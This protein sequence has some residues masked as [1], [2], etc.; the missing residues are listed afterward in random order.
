M[1]LFIQTFHHYQQVIEFTELGE[2]ELSNTYLISS[3]TNELYQEITNNALNFNV[4]YKNRGL[5]NIDESRYL[6]NIFG[7]KSYFNKNGST[8]FMNRDED[9]YSNQSFALTEIN[10]QLAIKSDGLT[11]QSLYSE[12]FESIDGGLISKNPLPNTNMPPITFDYFC[13]YFYK[14]DTIIPESKMYKYA[15]FEYTS[16]SKVKISIISIKTHTLLAMVYILLL[17]I[18]NM[19]RLTLIKIINFQ[20]ILVKILIQMQN[21]N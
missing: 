21:L 5:E 1:Q 18:I 11:H 2:Y 16:D 14:N 15:S 7:V 10:T 6:L 19:L 13:S 12:L 8:E 17:L 4:D 9:I 3:A 20:L